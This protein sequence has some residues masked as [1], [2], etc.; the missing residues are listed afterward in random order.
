MQIDPADPA[1]APLPPHATRRTRP[2]AQFMLSHPAHVFSLGFGTGLARFAPG[3]VGSL[4]GWVSF[5]ALDPYLT[6]RDWLGLIVVGFCAGV[7]LTGFTARKMGTAD[8]GPVNWDEIV[9]VWLVMLMVTPASFGAQCGAFLLFR[10]FD[11]VKPPPVSYFD[12]NFKGG[13]GIML[14]DLVAAFLTLLVI[15]LWRA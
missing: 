7:W 1:A 2:T 6:P 5:A 14:D 13:L 15:A 11:M 12:R 4:F 10:F 8:P 9:A 3:T